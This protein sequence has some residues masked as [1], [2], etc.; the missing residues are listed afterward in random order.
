MKMVM[1]MVKV[2]DT[3][4]NTSKFFLG[5]VCER[6][7]SEL[8]PGSGTGPGTGGFKNAGYVEFLDSMINLVALS[9]YDDLQL[10]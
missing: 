3:S 2:K 7:W 10:L 4:R 8:V 1:A 6:T 5:I 9:Q